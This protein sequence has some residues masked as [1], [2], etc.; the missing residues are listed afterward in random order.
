MKKARNG[1]KT[2]TDKEKT[3]AAIKAQKAKKDSMYAAEKARRAKNLEANRRAR[4]P[5]AEQKRLRDASNAPAKAVK[6]D[7]YAEYMKTVKGES[8]GIGKK[9]AP[10]KKEVSVKKPATG[11]PATRLQKITPKKGLSS[12]PLPERKKITF[13][14]Q[15]SESERKQMAQLKNIKEGKGSVASAQRKIAA[16]RAKERAASQK[17]S[18][19]AKRVDNKA[20]RVAKRTAIRAIRRGK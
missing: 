2:P 12:V 16:T 13:A 11:T 4:L 7:G 18:Q 5:L 8:L 3:D 14:K 20:G 1:V 6:K 9:A 17:A 10:V 15:Y 19:K